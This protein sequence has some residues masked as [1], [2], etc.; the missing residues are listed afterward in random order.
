M[1]KN[2]NRLAIALTA[3]GGVAIF[4]TTIGLVTR[5][6]YT[7]EN[8]RAELE[9]LVSRVQNVAFKSDVFDDST[10]YSQI[11]SQLFDQSG[12]LLAGT[13]LNKFISFYTQVNSKLRKF[14]PTFA[15]NKPF[16]EFIDLIPNDNDQS[17][18]LQFRAKHQVD[19]NHTAFSTIIS[20]KVSFAQRSQFALA[21]FN[22]NLEKITKSFKENIQ[23]L[24]RQDFSSSVINPSLTDQKIASL[25]RAEDFAADINRA[26]TEA[27]AIEKI[28]QYFPDFQKLINE[29]NFD[30]NNFFAFKQGT[31]YNFSLEKHPGT[32]NYILVG[33]NSVP[34]FLVKAELSDDA[35][36]EL[37]NFNIEDAQLL[38]KIDLVPQASSNS[39]ASQ[40]QSGEKQTKQPTYFADVD[41]ILSRISL[42]KLQFTDFKAGS[43]PVTDQAQTQASLLTSGSSEIKQLVQ[44]AAD[45][46]QGQTQPQTDQAAGGTR[47]Q[48]S[49]GTT[50]SNT[51]SNGSASGAE[52]AGAA[53]SAAGEGSTGGTTEQDDGQTGE[54]PT[55]TTP[56][57]PEDKTKELVKYL[58]IS[59]RTVNDFFASFNK[60]IYSS[61]REK[62]KEVVDKINSELLITPIS[63]DFGEF[64]QYFGQKQPQ[65]VDFYLDLSKAQEKDGVNADNS[66]LEIPV[67]INL[68]SSFFGDSEN[69]L[70]GSRTSVFEIP[71]FKKVMGTGAGTGTN[72]ESNLD[73]ERKTFY[74]LDGLP[75]TSASQPTSVS[76]SASTT[77]A[78]TTT[79]TNKQ[80]RIGSTT[81]YISKIELENLIGQTGQPSEGTD[82][83]T[84]SKAPKFEEIKK[85]IGNPFQYAY[86]FDANESMLKAW[87][88]QQK[89]PKLE[90][91]ANFTENNFI[92][93]DYKIK[94]L[95]SDKFFKNE[96]DVAS[97]Y[98][99]LIQ[100]EPAQVLNYLFEIAKANGLVDKNAS[101]NLNDIIDNNIFK[102]ASDVKLKTTENN[103]VYSLDF[104][105]QFLG[106]DSRGWISNLFLPKTVWEKTNTLIND[107]DI[108]NELNQYSA[109]KVDASASSGSG[110]G[111][112]GTGDDLY[113][114][115]QEAAK[116]IK[117]ELKKQSSSILKAGVDG[118]SGGG[119]GAGG[120]A[121][122]STQ[123]SSIEVAIKNFFTE[124]T[125][126]LSTLK[127][128]LLAFYFKAK[129]LTNFSAWSKLG[130]DLDYKI[131]FEK[132]TGS[133]STTSSGGETLTTPSGLEDYK[134]T[135]YYKVFDKKTGVDKYQTPKIDLNL[136]VNKQDTQRTE[137][138]ELNKAVLSIP[139]SFSL[140]YLK[141]DEFEK[142][143]KGESTEGT[144]NKKFEETSAFKEIQAKIQENN[145]D[146]KLSVVSIDEDKISP[147]KF[148]VV[149]LQI[150]KTTPPATEGGSTSQS[151]KSSLSFQV[152]IALDDTQK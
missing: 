30:K 41:D 59:T 43:T 83:T 26:G 36:F 100:M 15:P 104:N 85:I 48:A 147:Q 34:S 22:S 54:Q 132:Q 86:D 94:S 119:G 109:V 68:Y 18:E 46:T 79:T 115:L 76:V 126:P 136:W 67:V 140:F 1:P 42:R 93:S 112:S 57:Q 14:E 122:T 145:K 113:K 60:K 99:Y 88:G 2:T 81:A 117:D 139:P 137:R 149:N 121:A 77:G 19:N 129:E 146:L 39:E 150:E 7:G 69:K 21:E 55:V 70:L 144:D 73:T 80:I 105:N 38:E 31:I 125:Q 49:A 106:F 27:E 135:Y 12:K 23:N 116:K 82:Q 47:Q 72:I 74:N 33:P 45:L 65:G 52:G 148:K 143:K 92:A 123:P 89:F 151:V 84:E 96:Y 142:L 138:D 53:A 64:N 141:K 131:V 118:G 56:A 71:N 11:K 66:N 134:L 5:I 114:T 111:G 29:L 28:S 50:D 20:K 32:N 10:T 3:V 25:T 78:Q 110:M 128:L 108:F 35:K 152:R 17:F 90:D 24:R 97:F 16:L 9:S 44:V 95:K 61:T 40:D 120:S 37:K 127:D 124:K 130:N 133:A 102:I 91:F 8:P 103:P 58:E 98:A 13:D 63:L 51:G 62:S 101:I 107:G 87:V 6:R 75:T 4:A